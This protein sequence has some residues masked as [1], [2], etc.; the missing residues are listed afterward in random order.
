MF[1]GAEAPGYA[2]ARQESLGGENAV[3][4]SRIWL[5]IVL[6]CLSRCRAGA[7]Q[8]AA[9]ITLVVPIAAG[10]GVDAI[11][12]LFAEKLRSG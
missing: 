3:R 9:Q 1:A 10:G 6:L 5:T 12:R 4:G 7:I 11:G 2:S 8:S